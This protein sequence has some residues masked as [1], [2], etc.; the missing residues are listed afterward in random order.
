MP[1]PSDPSDPS[2][3]SWFRETASGSRR[4][5]TDGPFLILMTVVTIQLNYLLL[6]WRSNSNVVLQNNQQSS[7]AS[8]ISY[9]YN[10]LSLSYNFLCVFNT[11]ILIY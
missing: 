3:P 4:V 2:V 8:S 10:L 9:M 5:D 1:V 11:R 7:T 6:N